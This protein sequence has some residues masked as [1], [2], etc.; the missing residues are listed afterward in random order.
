MA[1]YLTPGTEDAFLSATEGAPSLIDAVIENQLSDVRQLLRDHPSSSSQSN[2]EDGFFP[3]HYAAQVDNAA[4]VGLLLSSP[5][6]D[7]NARDAEGRTSLHWSI[8]SLSVTT[9]A[10]LIKA[11]GRVDLPDSSGLLPVHRLATCQSTDDS[12]KQKYTQLLLIL[13]SINPAFINIP[14]DTGLTPLMIAAQSGNH[15]LVSVLLQF[16]AK[17]NVQDNNGCYPIHWATYSGCS[18]TI[19][20][21]LSQGADMWVKDNIGRFPVH[22]CIKFN[23]GSILPMFL[24]KD[25]NQSSNKLLAVLA[26]KDPSCMLLQDDNGQTPLKMIAE[27][28][29]CQE[30]ENGKDCCGGCS[31]VKPSYLEV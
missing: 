20:A 13:S 3:I 11:G 1:G 18:Q 28:E 15:T 10:A 26:K 23:H 21:L 31:G 25:P 4:M 12:F 8:F 2:P 22:I 19:L 30:E 16:N 14:A 17:V 6:T 9:T 7:I 27:K 24:S 29:D 5:F